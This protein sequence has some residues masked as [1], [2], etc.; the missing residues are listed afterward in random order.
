MAG[1][2]VPTA[3]ELEML[4]KGSSGAPNPDEVKAPS[5]EIVERAQQIVEQ[6]SQGEAMSQV[7]DTKD[8]ITLQDQVGYIAYVL[9]G[10]PFEHTYEFLGGRLRIRVQLDDGDLVLP[11]A[12]LETQGYGKLEAQ[13]QAMFDTLVKRLEENATNPSFWP[14]P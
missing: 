10:V 8:V 9:E 14:A 1:S 3:E 6:R 2:T 5:P 12:G 4:T 7:V 13:A 11:D